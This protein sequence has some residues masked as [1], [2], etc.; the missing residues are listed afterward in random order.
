M[1]AR[2]E[3]TKAEIGDLRLTKGS[4]LEALLEEERQAWR[5]SIHWDFGASADLIRR[6]ADLRAL[7]GSVLRVN[8]RVAGYAYHVAEET[9]TLIGNLFV[10]PPLATPEAEYRLLHA[11]LSEAFQ[12]RSSRVEAQLMMMRHR[13]EHGRLAKSFPGLSARSF[14]RYFMLAPLSV[15]APTREPP[16]IAIEPWDERFVESAARLIA[17]AYRSHIDS[18]INDQYR[19]AA[20]SRRFLSN[21]VLYPGCGAFQSGASFAAFHGTSY[22]ILGMSLASIVA[23]GTGHI[24]QICVA[25]QIQ[26]SG[27]GRAL[28]LRSLGGLR[29]A[30]CHEVSLTVTAEN[31]PAIRLYER[32]GFRVLREFAAHVWERDGPSGHV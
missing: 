11:T 2:P 23:P 19:T 22:E 25:P 12:N 4:D 21:I 3:D 6:Y 18:E 15:L 8:R 16:G 14:P 10:L 28:L 29:R 1:A 5:Q 30:G 13:P 24:T 9:K 17:G 26:N 27:V 20:G 7:A 31:A 32:L